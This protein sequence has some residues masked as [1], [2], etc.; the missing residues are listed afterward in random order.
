MFLCARTS[1][2]GPLVTLQTLSGLWGTS[3]ERERLS[4]AAG[5]SLLRAPKLQL[6]RLSCCGIGRAL[7]GPQEA[8]VH[9]S[10]CLGGKCYQVPKVFAFASVLRHSILRALFCVLWEPT[11][12]KDMLLG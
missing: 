6:P 10:L 2:E 5:R 8:R 7:W 9:M 12:C 1:Q 11:I 3:L 4:G